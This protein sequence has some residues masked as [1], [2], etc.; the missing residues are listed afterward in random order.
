M[1]LGMARDLHA[2]AIPEPG[3]RMLVSLK[4]GPGMKTID[5]HLANLLD[6]RTQVSVQGMDGKV[7]F[8]QYAW[9][10]AGY[11]KRLNLAEVPEGN[12]LFYV[13]NKDERY[14]QMIAISERGMDFFRTM[15]PMRERKAVA[16]LAGG[17]DSRR[18]RVIGYITQPD[19]HALGIQLANL[20]RWRA[21][22]RILALGESIAY[23]E[24][25]SDV[26]GYAKL[27]NFEG[28]PSGDYYVCV[29][30][31]GV[32]IVQFFSWSGEELEFQEMQRFIDPSIQRKGWAAR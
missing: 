9:G 5:V 31:H 11:A 25:I 32:S 29:E 18:G 17:D 28:M 26:Q 10:E 20:E 3:A 16:L 1:V 23:E 30:T 22:V 14:L 24:T 7:W 21:N 15:A 12:Y 2:N 13:E 27:I 4:R 8:S 6:K 19:E